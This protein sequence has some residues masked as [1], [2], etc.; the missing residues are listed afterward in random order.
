MD[1][2]HASI[3]F[4]RVSSPKEEQEKGGGVGGGGGGGGGRGKR[5]RELDHT[6]LTTSLAQCNVV[7]IRN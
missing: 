2:V 1:V 3:E 4:S 6:I 7:S 5:W